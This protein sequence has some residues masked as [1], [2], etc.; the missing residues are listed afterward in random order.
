MV[1]QCRCKFLQ[2]PFRDRKIR[3][4]DVQRSGSQ[5]LVVVRQRRTTPLQSIQL[6]EACGSSFA[7]EI[8]ASRISNPITCPSW[9]PSSLRRPSYITSRLLYTVAVFQPHH[10]IDGLRFPF[11]LYM[12]LSFGSGLGYIHRWRSDGGI[13]LGLKDCLGSISI[14]ANGTVKP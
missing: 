1:P 4:G 10:A 5:V 14:K 8:S 13:G 2:G 9:H 12:I 3:S 11:T 7:L 6:L